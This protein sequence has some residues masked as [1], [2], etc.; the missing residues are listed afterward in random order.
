MAGGHGHGGGLARVTSLFFDQHAVMSRVD[1]ATRR[2]LSRFGAYVRADAKKSI[3]KAANSKPSAPGR[4][5]K[6][7]K[8]TLKQH[9]YFS[10]DPIKQSVVIGPALLPRTRQDNLIMLEYGGTR[11]MPLPSY[12]GAIRRLAR[13]PARPFTRPAFEKNKPRAAS[14]YKDQVR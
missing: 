8:G 10:Y 7:R 14:L 6:S 4:P 2:A 9:I 12:G 5:P 3:R 11:R 13:Y 1:A